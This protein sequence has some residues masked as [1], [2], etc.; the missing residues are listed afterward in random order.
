MRL[1]SPPWIAGHRGCEPEL[2]NTLASCRRAVAEGADLIEVDVQLTRDG[3]LVLFHD[4]TLERLGGGD[5]RRVEELPE[6]VLR[7]VA[8][9]DPARR[10]PPCRIPSLDELFV[11]LP[12][13]FPVNLEAKRFVADRERF[14]V[15]L[16]RALAGRVNVLVSS[17]DG[18]LLEALR[19][20]APTLPLAPLA[21]RLDAA[22]RGLADR[23][24]A[25]SLHLGE[26][27]DGEALRE[28]PWPVLV[29]TVNDGRLARDLL[30]RGVAGLF[31][32]RPGGLRRELAWAAPGRVV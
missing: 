9:R 29:Y 23:L 27:P 26:A 6:A 25:W 19:R 31:S 22:V 10:A 30:A 18:P 28:L 13:G 14:A 1:P 21:E 5:P 20:Q 32:D 3:R 8:L 4:A 11:A 12:A 17:F 7:R 2:E 16:A 15:A 24:S